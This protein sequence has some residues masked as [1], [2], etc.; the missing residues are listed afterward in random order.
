M[1]SSLLPAK[2]KG[3][4]EGSFKAWVEGSGQMELLQ[5]CKTCVLQEPWHF[6]HVPQVCGLLLTHKN[7]TRAIFP[8]PAHIFHQI[9]FALSLHAGI[10]PNA[11]D[12]G[13]PS[14]IRSAACNNRGGRGRNSRCMRREGNILLVQW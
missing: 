1:T 10:A 3:K 12:W 2:A 5:C 8:K 4:S 11:Q 6:S 13:L 14:V 9:L 7:P